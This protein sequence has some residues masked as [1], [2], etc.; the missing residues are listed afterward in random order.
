[1]ALSPLAMLPRW[2]VVPLWTSMTFAV[3]PVY[4][5]LV[6][7]VMSPRARGAAVAVSVLLFMCW[8]GTRT[9]L[10]FSRLSIALAAGAAVLADTQPTAAG[11]LLGLALVKPHIAGPFALWALATRRLQVLTTA[12]AVVI[13]G[14]ALYCLHA[15]TDPVIVMTQYAGILSSLFAGPEAMFGLTSLQPWWLAVGG[16][17]VAVWLGVAM[18]LLAIPFALAMPANRS[19]E[20]SHAALALFCLWSLL[21]LYNISSNVVV[22]VLPAFVWLL[23]VDS[24]GTTPWVAVVG[25]IQAAMML[26]IPVHL[27]TFV[28]EVG[29]LATLVSSVDRV[30]VLIAFAAIVAFTLRR[31]MRSIA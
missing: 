30:V 4:A 3:T 15:R 25:L 12:A 28:G 21:T 11:V 9:F 5:F 6:V 7:K 8:G 19:S 2:W 14:W 24:V 1:V 10:E 27:R 31:P 29:P 23:C 16:A 20:R 17:G 26:D 22:L 18:L 13:A